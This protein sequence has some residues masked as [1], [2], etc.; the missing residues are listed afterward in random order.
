M[1]TARGGLLQSDELLKGTADT[2]A[3]STLGAR[4]RDGDTCVRTCTRGHHTGRGTWAAAGR[5]GGARR[6]Q[7]CQLS[8]ARRHARGP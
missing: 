5:P 6:T 2:Q 7:A 8:T 1:Q 4:R 3:L